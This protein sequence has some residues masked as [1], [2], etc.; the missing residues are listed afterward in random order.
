MSP[1]VCGGPIPLCTPPGSPPF[2]SSPLRGEGGQGGKVLIK[3]H[4]EEGSRKSFSGLTLVGFP[5]QSL[6][7]GLPEK[8]RQEPRGPQWP[9]TPVQV[10]SN[11]GVSEKA[12]QEVGKP[13]KVKSCWKPTV[14]SY[15]KEEMKITWGT[16]LVVQCLRLHTSTAEG[17]G[18]IP[19]EGTKI[20]H[21]G[22]N[23]E[24]KE[25]KSLVR[26]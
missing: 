2:P 23:I 6:G 1:E 14:N 10:F 17:I 25:R 11:S 5:L 19:G 9:Q 8:P 18:S 3:L 20:P 22:Q 21:Q 4:V 7:S 16:S 12:T 13:K 15:R 24:G 26:E